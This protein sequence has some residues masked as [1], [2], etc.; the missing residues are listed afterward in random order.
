L[1]K[2]IEKTDGSLSSVLQPIIRQGHLGAFIFKDYFWQD[3]DNYSSLRLAKRGLLQNLRSKKDGVVSR[4]GNR[5]LSLAVTSFVSRFPITPNVLSLFGF[6]IC[7]CSAFLFARGYP[8]VGGLLAQLASVIDGVDGEIA[9]LKF[10]ESPFGAYFDSLL[11]CYADA[12]IIG[13]M[14][15]GSLLEG[16]APLPVL[17][18]GFMALTASP[19]SMLAKEKYT[20]LTGREYNPFK[21]EGFLGY[22]P[23]NRDGR[24]AII[25]FGGIFNQLLPTLILLA[26]LTN[27]QAVI[28][29]VV[30]RRHFSC[31]INKIAGIT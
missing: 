22:L 12:A 6:S 17:L 13:G 21:V 24:M 7:L 16:T 10:N 18:A 5:R 29:L 28:R 9:R 8:L 14:V 20:N 4:Y 1:E 3:V 31:K 23:V 25:M 27:M 19:L 11:D 2:E 30:L 15:A 26:V